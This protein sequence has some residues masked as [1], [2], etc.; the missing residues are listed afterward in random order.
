M[1]NLQEADPPGLWLNIDESLL[2]QEATVL[3]MQMEKE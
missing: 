1:I 2:P 3:R